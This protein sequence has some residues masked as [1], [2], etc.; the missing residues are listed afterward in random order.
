MGNGAM[1]A[2]KEN[3]TALLAQAQGGK[4]EKIDQLMQLLYGE[5]RRLAASYL[6]RERI[7]HTLQPTALVNEAY[8]RLVEQDGTDWKNRSHFLAIAAQ[9]MRRVLVDH[10]RR[11]HA[12]KRGGPL[13]KLSLEQAIL[14]SKEQAGELVVLDELMERLAG[15]DPQQARIVELRVF[16]GLTVEETAE[17]LGVSPATVK[18][19]WTMAKAWLAREMDRRSEA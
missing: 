19:D 10:A 7:G 1:T 2:S 14:Y 17:V 15:I 9:A 12:A 8:L 16:G 13:P 4:Q 3:I 11:G 6:R 5:L 18:R